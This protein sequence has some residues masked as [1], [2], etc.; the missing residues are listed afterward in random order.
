MIPIMS[1]MKTAGNARDT[2]L[3]I[4][5]SI[6]FQ[7]QPQIFATAAAANTPMRNGICIPACQMKIDQAVATSIANSGIID[8]TKVSSFF[9]DDIS[10]TVDDRNFVAK[11]RY[12]P[13][14]PLERDE[15]VLRV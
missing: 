12:N 10:F 9:I 7:R 4:I 2:R 1:R 5:F 3:T 8:A 14:H 11:N 15:G 6:S 13:F